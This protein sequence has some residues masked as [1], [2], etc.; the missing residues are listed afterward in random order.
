V[1]NALLRKDVLYDLPKDFAPVTN[2]GI[3]QGYLLVVRQEL[4]VK[5]VGELIEGVSE[6]ADHG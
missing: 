4:P 3:G 5:S 1:L 6:C 2:V